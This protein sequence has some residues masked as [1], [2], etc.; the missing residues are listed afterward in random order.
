M[1]LNAIKVRPAGP[2]DMDAIKEIVLQAWKH[3]A[4][5]HLMEKKHGVI[6]HIGW[7]A[8]MLASVFGCFAKNFE[9]VIVTECDGK[10]VGFAAYA[11]DDRSKTGTVGYNAV[12]PAA[13]GQGVGKAQITR[14]LALLRGQGM[15]RAVVTT[16]LD[17]LHGAARKVYEQAGFTPLATYIKYSMEL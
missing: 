4:E 11:T 1:R 6:A 14:I 16:G 8:K 3:R 17:D 10:V 9:N 13:Q 15:K 2:A 12:H 5:D 7:Q